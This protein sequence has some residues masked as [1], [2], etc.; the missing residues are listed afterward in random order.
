V[1][2]ACDNNSGG[3]GLTSAL[4]FTASSRTTYYIMV[5]GVNGATGTIYL[6]YRLDRKPT[7]S[8]IL[9]QTIPED[10]AT[11][12]LAF[13]VADPETPTDRLLVFAS[14]SNIL[15]V[16][17]SAF[18]FS[19]TGPSRT[20]TIRPTRFRCGN[21]TVTLS[22]SDGANVVQ[23]SFLLTVT[24]VNHA[25]VAAPDYI[26]GLGAPVYIYIP[27]L[28]AN[29]RDVDGDPLTLSSHSSR[30]YFGGTLSKRG[31]YLMYW[32][33]AYTGAAAGMVGSD[34]FTYV[35]SDSRGGSATGTVIVQLG[36]DTL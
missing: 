21:A 13:T 30:T 31:S 35:V 18:S 19:G 3:D 1:P 33:P 26:A 15:L 7:I 14:S 8:A 22:F 11:A 16:P 2:V 20:L 5:D 10:Q 28:L 25:P 27:L 23:T 24:H 36:G 32:P 17:S 12:P 9:N 29:D 4:N 6:N 34:T